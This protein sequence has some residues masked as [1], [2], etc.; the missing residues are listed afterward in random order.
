MSAWRNS[1]REGHNPEAEGIESFR[2]RLFDRQDEI[3]G[4]GNSAIPER[5]LRQKKTP[6]F[7][8]KYEQGGGGQIDPSLEPDG[9]TASSANKPNCFQ[10]IGRRGDKTDTRRQR[11]N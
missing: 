9:I 6:K 3:N 4:G 8:S 1:R 10:P 11:A 2:A 7:P 5:A